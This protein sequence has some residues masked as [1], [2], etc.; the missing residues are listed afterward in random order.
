MLSNFSMVGRGRQGI[1]SAE[2]GTVEVGNM[3]EIG[4]V[5]ADPVMLDAERG[6]SDGDSVLDDEGAADGFERTLDLA[7]VGEA[8]GIEKLVDRVFLHV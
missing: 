2:R 3:L 1:M 6:S 7:D 5:G 8:V 4:A